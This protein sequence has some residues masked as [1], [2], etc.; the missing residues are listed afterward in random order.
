MKLNS[1]I[2]I[3]GHKGMVGSACWSLLEQ[4]GY[5]NLI[6]YSK[7]ELDLRDKLSVEDFFKKE[8]PE[9]VINAAA[10]VGGILAN[11]NFPYDFLN[12]NLQIQLNLI[13]SANLNNVKKFIFLGSS[14][15]YPKHCQQPIKENYLLNGSLE[16]TN[17]A[18]AIAKIAG[19]K[20]CQSIRNQLK[21]EF[22][23]LMPTN[24]YGLNDTFDIENSHVIPSMIVKFHNAKV[25]NLDEV[26]LWGTGDPLREFLHVDDLAEAI[27]VILNASELSHDYYN[28]GS[29]EEISIKDLGQLIKEIV[30]FKGSIKWDT[31]KP[32][33]TPRKLLDSKRIKD[34]GWKAHKS[35]DTTIGNYYINFKDSIK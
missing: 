21:K 29:G 35:L 16:P 9:F 10:K 6:G 34:L 27:L 1:K 22:V 19:L 5:Q 31:S 30:G 24:L 13:N 20:L 33:G 4:K 17:D 12:E 7:E 18:F 14:C 15:I 32:D 26:L 11:K 3:A 25:K 23:T 2:Y 8:K 28:I